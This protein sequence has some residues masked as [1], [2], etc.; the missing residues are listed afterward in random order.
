M[1]RSDSL[2]DQWQAENARTTE[3]A[4]NPD[5]TTGGGSEEAGDRQLGHP[6]QVWS[7]SK[8]LPLPAKAGEV[9][10]I[11]IAALKSS[12]FMTLSLG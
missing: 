5:P 4:G 7:A 2:L 3:S 10:I 8:S 1:P 11:M 12:F 6:L 9:T